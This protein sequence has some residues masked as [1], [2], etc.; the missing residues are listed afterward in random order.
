[1]N[2]LV[3]LHCP[4]DKEFLSIRRKEIKD[5]RH[6][7]KDVARDPYLP[8]SVR[9]RRMMELR[10]ASHL[11]MEEINEKYLNITSNYL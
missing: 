5:I 9:H 1:M 3:D 4:I 8:K 10:E 2:N 11:V 7:I 6:Q